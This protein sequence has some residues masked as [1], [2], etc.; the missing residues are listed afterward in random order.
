MYVSWTIE[1]LYSID[2]FVPMEV[3]KKK[4]QFVPMEDM[5]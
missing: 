3:D 1:Y 5:I 4:K 2:N